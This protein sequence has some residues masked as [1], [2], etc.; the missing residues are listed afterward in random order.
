MP[1]LAVVTG[2]DITKYPVFCFIS[3]TEGAAM[4]QL[5]FQGF[6]SILVAD[7]FRV[8][9]ASSRFAQRLTLDLLDTEMKGRLFKAQT[10]PIFDL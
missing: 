6:I 7:L 5:P 8:R 10:V 2:F 1:P 3:G 9:H 4:N